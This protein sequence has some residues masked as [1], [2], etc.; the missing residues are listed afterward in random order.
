[1]NQ[2]PV[3][4][5]TLLQKCDIISL[6]LRLSEKTHHIIGAHELG[7]MKKHAFLINTARADLIDEP[8]LTEALQQKKIGGAALDVFS[9][10]PLPQDSPL[11]SLDNVTLTPH[12]AG[13]TVDSFI[14]SVE[15]IVKAL[16]CLFENQPIPGLVE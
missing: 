3:S 4:L 9:Q 15:L 8:A 13:T 1:M 11:L 12:L 2:N 16:G 5:E 14:N 10:E 6:H 7:L